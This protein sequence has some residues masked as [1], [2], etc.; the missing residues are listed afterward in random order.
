MVPKGSKIFINQPLR[1]LRV[2]A[3]DAGVVV[4]IEGSE[5]DDEIGFG[6][7]DA[8]CFDNLRIGCKMIRMQKIKDHFQKLHLRGDLRGYRSICP[9]R[10][11]TISR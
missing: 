10:V 6:G 4:G 9:I 3:F 1:N 2:D 11:R 5:S 7:I 8:V